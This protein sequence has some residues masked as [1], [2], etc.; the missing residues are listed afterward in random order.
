MRTRLLPLASLSVLISVLGALLVACGDDEGGARGLDPGSPNAGL[1]TVELTEHLSC[2]FG[3]AISDESQ[4]TL[5]SVHHA[6]G[7]AP[8]V[9][10][11]VTL[12]DPAWGAEVR[13][14]SDLAA[15]WCTD[16][17]VDPQAEVEETWTVVEGTLRFEGEVPPFGWSESVADDAPEVVRAELMGVVV[18]AP[19][20]ERVELGDLSLSNRSWGFLA[21]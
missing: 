2:G 5:L 8:P 4:E 12:P 19:D 21:G 18:E 7:D 10:R 14:G 13:V 9:G 3:F 17:I 1:A 6:G 15:N 20:G 16:V 11:T